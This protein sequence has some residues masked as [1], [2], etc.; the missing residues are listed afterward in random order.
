MKDKHAYRRKGKK[1]QG[2]VEV[3]GAI[4]RTIAH[5]NH[6]EQGSMHAS[7][8]CFI[9]ALSGSC[10][11]QRSFANGSACC[12]TG[13][14]CSA[15]AAPQRCLQEQSDSGSSEAEN[16]NEAKRESS[17]RRTRG[18]FPPLTAEA[19]GAPVLLPS[20]WWHRVGGWAPPH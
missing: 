16:V 20:P 4:F 12:P 2:F 14:T 5:S 9:M 1:E 11:H 15:S 13:R 8:L 3:G 17:R 10:A 19:A 6:Q 18:V 7:A